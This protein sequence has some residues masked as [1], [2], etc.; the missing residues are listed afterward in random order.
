MGKKKMFFN[1]TPAFL[2]KILTVVALDKWLKIV[3]LS[4]YYP[5]TRVSLSAAL[6]VTYYKLIYLKSRNNKINV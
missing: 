5:R 3:G 4:M 6:P 1:D 2:V